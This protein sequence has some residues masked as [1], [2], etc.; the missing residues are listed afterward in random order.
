MLNTT[1]ETFQRDVIDASRELPVLVDFWAPW[2][3]PCRTLGPM[4]ERLEQDSAG[5]FPGQDQF[6]REP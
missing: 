2:C 4:L 5:R 1:G 6:G 3:G